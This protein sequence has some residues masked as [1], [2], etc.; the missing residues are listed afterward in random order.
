MSSPGNNRLKY[1]PAIQ[2]DGLKQGCTG[3]EVLFG[4]LNIHRF[5]KISPYEFRAGNAGNWAQWPGSLAFDQNK[6]GGYIRLAA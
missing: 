2:L 6:S 1:S 3:L 5:F 4:A